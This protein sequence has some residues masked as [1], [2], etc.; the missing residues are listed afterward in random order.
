MCAQ[1]FEDEN[2]IMTSG[3]RLNKCETVWDKLNLNYEPGA[4]P[5]GAI[6]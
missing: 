1:E 5:S 6:L 3:N 2:K 4:E